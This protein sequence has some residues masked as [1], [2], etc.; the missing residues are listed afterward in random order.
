MSESEKRLSE[1]RRRCEAATEGPWTVWEEPTPTMEDAARAL[2]EQVQGTG[3]GFCKA[4]FL[5]E[6]GGKCPATTGCG[7]TSKSNAAFIA[8]ARDDIPWLLDRVQPTHRVGSAMRAAPIGRLPV[9]IMDPAGMEER[10]EFVNMD[11]IRDRLGPVIEAAVAMRACMD[12]HRC[13]CRPLSCD[14]CLA[15][16]EARIAFDAALVKACE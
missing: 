11:T 14:A 8:H 9:V 12:E 15:D 3:D 2:T 1:I 4:L 10:I 13:D 6:A 7:P 16:N 5:L